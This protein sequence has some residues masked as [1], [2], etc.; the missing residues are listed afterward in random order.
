MKKV[1]IITLA[2]LSIV[3]LFSSNFIFGSNESEFVELDYN[4]VEKAVNQVFKNINPSKIG[5]SKAEE[6]GLSIAAE[7]AKEI[8]IIELISDDKITF[9]AMVEHVML[10]GKSIAI[11]SIHENSKQRANI[12]RQSIITA[13]N[14]YGVTVSQD[15]ITKYIDDKIAHIVNEDKQKF[16]VSIGLTTYEL[17]YVFDRDIYAMDVLWD[18]IIPVLMKTYPQYEDENENNYFDRIK[19][20]FYKHIET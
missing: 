3:I 20:N 15:E 16:A 14:V 4:N 11:N 19:E 1:T 2:T 6:K 18:K 9:R 10:G 12:L 17:D 7:K 8:P 13:E 5:L